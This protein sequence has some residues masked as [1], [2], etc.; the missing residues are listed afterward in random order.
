MGPEELLILRA[1]EPSDRAW[2]AEK[3]EDFYRT[4]HDFDHTFVD[5]VNDA[6]DNLE[7]H[8]SDLCSYLVAECENEPIGCIFMGVDG[9][10]RGRI[11]LFFVDKERQGHGTGTRLLR[12][13]VEAARQSDFQV[14]RVSTFD[15]HAEA[16]HLYETAGFEQLKTTTTKAF[17]RYMTQL[18]YELSLREGGRV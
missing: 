16:C 10:G 4:H 1:Y 8:A 9:P 7:T 13:V 3:H 6:L 5:A 15:Q 2:V 11:R 17:G 12:A 14:V 18:D